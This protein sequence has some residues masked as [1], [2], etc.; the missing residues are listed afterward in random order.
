MMEKAIRKPAKI[1]KKIMK[2]YQIHLE[3][4][5][6][7][8]PEALG[9]GLETILAP[10]GAPGPKNIPKGHRSFRPQGPSCR[11]KFKLFRFFGFRFGIYF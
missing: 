8:V 11:P 10:K 7:G 4:R 9:R 3:L 2:I 5:S 6:G 1:I